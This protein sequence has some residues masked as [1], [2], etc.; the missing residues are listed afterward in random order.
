MVR[1]AGYIPHLSEQ[2]IAARDRFALAA[3]D[4][5]RALSGTPYAALNPEEA[6]KIAADWYE[7][8]AHVLR[9]GSLVQMEDFLRREVGRIGPDPELKTLRTLLGV[10]DETHRQC[11]WTSEAVNDMRVVAEG[12][13][14]DMGLTKK[15]AEEVKP[16][17]EAKEEEKEAKKVATVAPKRAKRARMAMTARVQAADINAEIDEVV[18]TEN[19]TREGIL[20]LSSQPY[21]PGMRLRVILPYTKR[22]DEDKINTLSAEVVRVEPGAGKPAVAVKFIRP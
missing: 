8:C 1:R 13:L 11:G 6:K 4:R 7:A 17:V 10:M 18:Q 22:S 12:V 9:F 2:E 3:A 19:V 14:G 20:F 16:A 21:K 15:V 5:L